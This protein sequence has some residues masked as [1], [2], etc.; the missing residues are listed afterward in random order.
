MGKTDYSMG[1]GKYSVKQKML[2]KRLMKKEKSRDEAFLK[3]RVKR[4]KA[5]IKRMKS[6]K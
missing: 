3:A 6:L 2:W 4:G 5:I 1:K